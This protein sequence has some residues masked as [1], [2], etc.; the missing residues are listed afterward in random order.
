MRIRGIIVAWS[1]TL[2]LIAQAKADPLY[3]ATDLGAGYTLQT[4]P[5]GS[6]YGV[7]NAV[8]T[9]TYAFDKAP[10]QVTS[11]FSNY[12]PWTHMTYDP[13]LSTFFKINGYEAYNYE[14]SRNDIVTTS[15]GWL[16]SNDFNP[17]LDMNSSGQIVGALGSDG[18]GQPQS[19]RFSEPG[20]KNHPDSGIGGEYYSDELNH[21]VAPIPG[22]PYLISAFKIDD[23]GR[24][25]AEGDNG[26]DYLLTPVALGDPATV[27][28]PTSLMVFAVAAAYGLF[29]RWPRG[30]G[31]G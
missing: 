15:I 1:L 24:I 6:A 27:P 3:S 19:A 22:S 16:G 8:G 12:D 5:D 13:N 7:T 4:N 10:V 31:C 17:I 18:D 21:Y 20:M 9:I 11:T 14:V 23:L 28:E 29:R 25:L 2:S 30:R 26:H